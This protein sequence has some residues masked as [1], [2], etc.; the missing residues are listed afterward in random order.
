[1]RVNEILQFILYHFQEALYSCNSSTKFSYTKDFSSNL[2]NYQRE[3]YL[4]VQLSPEHDE[5]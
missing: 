2:R 3:F 5:G 4:S 1:M